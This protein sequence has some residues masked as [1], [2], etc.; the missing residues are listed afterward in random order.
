MPVLRRL[1]LLKDYRNLPTEEAAMFRSYTNR[2]GKLL[3]YAKNPA[4]A[5][6]N[7]SFEIFHNLTPN[8]FQSKELYSFYRA[9]FDVT[10]YYQHNTAGVPKFINS[11]LGKLGPSGNLKTELHLKNLPNT[12]LGHGGYQWTGANADDVTT[13]VVNRIGNNLVFAELKNRVDSGCT[14]GRREIWETKFLK[15][16]EHIV[17]NKMLYALGTKKD[18]LP[19]MLKHGGINCVE[20]YLGILFDIK[21]ESATVAKDKAYICYGG[22]VQG[23]Q[24]ILEF[25]RR[26]NIRYNEVTPADTT[27]E[28]LL[29]EF[30]CN[31][32]TVKLGAEY[33]NA[34]IDKLFKGK[35]AD[36]STLKS[37]ID[38][39][40]YD[41]L[42]LSQLLA[43][44]E[45]SLLLS[46]GNN[47][48]SNITNILGKDLKLA[49]S[50]LIW[51]DIRYNQ[52]NKAFALLN[53]IVDG[54]ER[55][56]NLQALPIP[57]MVVFMQSYLKQYTIKD[58]I[59][60]IIQI[61]A[62]VGSQ[63]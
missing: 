50:I 35:G 9:L 7:F 27:I 31:G 11:L 61:L 1:L 19:N 5:A 22:M 23:Y 43:V 26:N 28:D 32:L 21:G 16:I 2:V 20:M 52:P 14:A 8:A 51:K 60:D 3:E 63:K 6:W 15:I 29:V 30:Q 36:L 47:Y 10:S 55:Q 54:V 39:I 4:Q 59:G 49:Q 46:F 53:E 25:L 44:S 17:R 37:T 57:I 12:L 34:V 58:Y 38:S 62:S 41:D 40:T 33:G 42:W 56:P 45:R 48:V 24:R 18:S 13:D